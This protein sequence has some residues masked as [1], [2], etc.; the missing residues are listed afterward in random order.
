MAGYEEERERY[1]SEMKEE[2]ESAKMQDELG[3]PVE[4][5]EI[6]KPLYAILRYIQIFKKLSP[7]EK[8]AFMATIPDEYHSKIE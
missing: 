2:E 5:S 1:I 3:M 6:T 7:G 4:V 8:T